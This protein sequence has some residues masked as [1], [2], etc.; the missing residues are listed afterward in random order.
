M[1][2]FKKIIDYTLKYGIKMTIKRIFAKFHE[3][4]N[5]SNY[6]VNKLVWKNNVCIL[7][8]P[9][10]DYIAKLIYSELEIIGCNVSVYN[11]L[12]LRYNNNEYVY[13]IIAPQYFMSLPKNRIVIQMEQCINDRWFTDKYISVLSESCAIFDYSVENIKYMQEKGIQLKQLYYLPIGYKKKEINGI[14]KEYDVLFYGDINIRRS[15][16]LNELS[17]EFNIKIIRNCFGENLYK[18]INKAKIVINLHYYENAM[19]ET[20]RLY[21]VLSLNSCIIISEKT[22]NLSEYDNLKNIIDFVNV[23]NVKELSSRIRF[24]LSDDKM[25]NDKIIEIKNYF[26]NNISL[27]SFYFNRFLLAKDIITYE[28][29]YERFSNCFSIDERIICLSL[30]ETVS[31]RQ[32]FE[33]SAPFLYNI[34]PGLRHDIG[35]IGCGLSYKFI[36]SI[37][38]EMNKKYVT[39]CEDD[40]GF[41][42]DFERRYSKI[43]EYLNKNDVWDVFSGLMADASSLKVKSVEHVDDIDILHVDKMMSMVFNIYNNTIFDIVKKWNHVNVDPENNTIDKYL[44]KKTNL[45]VIVTDPFLVYHND[46]LN[47]TLWGFNNSMYNPMINQASAQIK[48]LK[49]NN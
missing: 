12:P 22:F 20:T 15:K 6:K 33:A 44:Q 5:N 21:E 16:I 30:S 1:L 3:M 10:C 2:Y 24:W 25:R 13:I 48:K 28:E 41:T 35:W 45:N 8:P 18:E 49:E 29:F 39:I 26:D 46:N 31:R 34:F 40:V 27:F 32:S 43:I 38:A 14:D 11:K 9:H 42:S 23:G 7:T 37:A 47:S 4:L 36:L 19:L 17:K